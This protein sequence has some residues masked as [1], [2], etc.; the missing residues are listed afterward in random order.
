M[1]AIDFSV[2]VEFGVGLAGFSGVVV[3]FSRRSGRLSEYDSFRVVQLLMSALIPAFVGLL[4]PILASFQI[5]GETARRISSATLM[6]GIAVNTGVAIATARRMSPG[7]RRSL[8]PTV[9][10]FSLGS[11]ALFLVW[12]GLNL[13]GWPWPPSFGPVLLGMV[14]LLVL[15]SIM[16]FRLLLVRLGD[17]AD[18]G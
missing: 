1:S 9:W 3:A 18:A 5:E 4:P 15:A 6:A 14:C 8:S 7:A 13:M 10:R 2:F 11:S 12:N 16:F 17:D